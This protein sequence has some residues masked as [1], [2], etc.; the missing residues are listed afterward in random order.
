[1]NAARILAGGVLTLLALG[2]TAAPALAGT[3]SAS[4]PK[5]L[6]PVAAPRV[7]GVRPPEVFQ[8]NPTKVNPTVQPNIMIVGQ[9][10]TPAT[11]VQVGTRPA[12]TVQ[13]PD[14]NHLLVKLPDH[15]SGGTYQI[16]V[17]NEA[18]SVMAN[19]SLV[20]DNTGDQP[21]TLTYLMGGGFLAFLVLVMRL[22][23]TPGL[24]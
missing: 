15:L 19:D 21:S 12:T 11:T 7:S 22:A 10:L 8:V 24:S 2:L 14:A 23:R 6:P 9:F 3:R 5:A 13:V 4:A 18:G 17:T 1:M 20:V 16:E